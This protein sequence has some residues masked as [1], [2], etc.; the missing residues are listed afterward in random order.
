MENIKYATFF[1]GA[2]N[3]TTTKEYQDSTYIGHL[4]AIRGYQV[5]NGGYRGL[6]EAVSFGVKLSSR[7]SK[8]IGYTCKSFGS[9][10]GN[11]YLDEVIECEDIFDRLRGLINESE[12]FVVQKGGIGTLAELFLTL[13]IVRKVKNPPTI[14]LIGEE[15]KKLIN[16]LDGLIDDKLKSS[17]IL[18]EDFLDFEFKFI[19]A[20][21]TNI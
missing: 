16:S 13:D 20:T 9:T 21:T 5:K 4:L 19:N 17:I 11:Q 6:M 12:V 3:D 10:K 18:C 2:M 7:M 15:H 14:Y 1:G 8:A